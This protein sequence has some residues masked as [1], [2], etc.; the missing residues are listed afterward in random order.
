MLCRALSAR[1]FAVFV[2]IS[3]LFRPTV[4]RYEIAKHSP[5][6]MLLATVVAPQQR[7]A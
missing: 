6:Y 3:T 1:V 5:L 2:L 4:F 7:R